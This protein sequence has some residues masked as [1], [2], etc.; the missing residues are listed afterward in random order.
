[1]RYSI[2]R[3]PFVSTTI[4]ASAVCLLPLGV[5]NALEDL[6]AHVDPL[7]GTGPSN[8]EHP[9]PGGRG[10]SVFPG[11]SLPFGM[12]QWSP[13]TPR[14]EPSGYSYDDREI[15]GFSLT[16]FSGAGCD[17]FA[18]LPIL[19]TVGVR[20]RSTP[21]GFAHANE[22]ASPGYYRV[23]LDNGVKVELTATTRTGHGRFAFPAGSAAQN[24]L[25]DARGSA[26]GVRAARVDLEDST[27]LSGM[28]ASG[29][30]CGTH[31]EYTLYFAVKFDSAYEAASRWDGGAL[32]S[33]P[34]AGGRA[35]QMKV[36][37]SYVS[38]AN[39]KENLD[40]ENPGW[41]FEAMRAAA[42]ERWNEALARVT[43]SGGESR[44]RRI[45]YTAL[46]HTLLHPNVFSDVNG[47]YVGFDRRMHR[48]EG[49]TQYANFSGWD[50]YRSQ[51]PLLALLFP[52]ET[53][54]MMQSMVADG[55]Q[56][57]ALPKWAQANGE[58]GVMV[59]DP[60]APIVA[61]A[62]AFG[63]RDFDARS[64]LALLQRSAKVPGTA[65][66]GIVMRPG[67]AEYLSY[68]YIPE[69]VAGVWGGVATGM[70]YQGADFAIARLAA[71]LGETQ[72]AR[73]FL[74]RSALWQ[75][76]LDP[77]TRLQRPRSASGA[78]VDGSFGA[79]S[80]TGMVEGNAEQYVWMVPH[81]PKTLRDG[82]GGDSIMSSRLDRLF[83]RLNAGLEDPY[84]YM[85]NEPNFATPWLYPWARTPWRT[86]DV[87][88]RIME[89]TFTD[90]AG[91][92]PG[93]DDLGATS[94]W[95]VWAALGL[96]PVAP[97]D[98]GLVLSSPLFPKAV[99]A[100]GDG[101][102]LTIEANG[103]PARYI[104][105]AMLDGVEHRTAWLDAS[106][107]LEGASLQ[108][109]LS[110]HP[111]LWASEAGDEPPARLP[112]RFGSWSEALNH[113]G[114][115]DS[116]AG[117]GLAADFDG[118]GYAYPLAELRAAGFASRTPLRVEGLVFP[119]H[120]LGG[121]ALDNLI[122]VGQHID[123][124]ATPGARRLGFLGAASQG[125]SSGQGELHYDDGTVQTF[126]LGFSDWTLNGGRS[127][128]AFGNKT[129]VTLP[130]R[131]TR[132]GG[133]EQVA[134]H[135]FLTEIPLDSAKTL[136]SVR[137]PQRLDRGMLHV[138]AMAVGG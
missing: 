41:D 44:D 94:S 37:L 121:G 62:Y 56:C 96:Y 53:S 20:N 64:A 39:A 28:V 13:D 133:R 82:L 130:F 100:L 114:V 127:R 73:E 24:L 120:D 118:S 110:R 67:L 21:V 135:V 109:D 72:A 50:I 33:F 137:L 77:S 129:V 8:V 29:N 65:C 47:D 23:L 51:V 38:V 15:K 2:S 6:A 70:E 128:P 68:G 66:N 43:V 107:L 108:F 11:A 34:G 19:P 126:T 85:G 22:E 103:A 59:G 117:A 87:V 31:N 69:G 89:E 57:G 134:S 95:Y 63:A 61:G 98:S 113:H 112:L 7:I 97:G 9:V 75:Y 131:L 48:A 16:H 25:F 3:F 4:L 42:R 102:S 35:V 105:R 40:A 17:N 122:S 124:Q 123:V 119:L 90:G 14:G 58:T 12:I 125:P 26:T 116:D 74:A 10:G 78:W 104:E 106:Q 55:Q 49:Y 92:L 79:H 84:F 32:V 1:M 115:R 27:Q 86:Q 136:R 99:V 88:R 138:F 60:A 54:D 83:T 30:F 18:D 71:A 76:Q 91:G 52:R 111:T 45:F 132:D 46:Y 93:N 101:K 36:G 80:T 5:A 81:D